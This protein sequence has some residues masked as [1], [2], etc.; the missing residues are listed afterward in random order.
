MLLK[1]GYN[2]QNSN[3]RYSV[4]SGV[5]LLLVLLAACVPKVKPP[6]TAPQALVKIRPHQFPD[7]SDDMSY[8]S[9]ETA[10]NQSLDYLNRLD[11]S[12]PFRFGPDTFT[13]SHL[14][15]SINAFH[16]LIKQAPSV[17]ELRKAIETSYWVYRSVGSD[18]QGKVMFTGYYEPAL[19]GSMR[20]SP[21]YP[22]PI[23]RKPDDWVRI[24][25]GLFNPKYAGERIVGRYVNESVVPC[26]SREEIDSKGLLLQKGSELLWVSDRVDLFFLHIQGSGRVLLEDGTVLHVNYDC[27]N[28]RPYRSIG[29]LLIDEGTIPKEEISMQRIRA[30]MN[31]HPEDIE[32]VFNHNQSYVFFRLVDQ[33]PMGALEV[34]LTPGRSVATDLRLFPRA[35][36]AF[37][38][39]EKP[40]VV[41]DGTIQSW[42][43]FGRFVL[44]QD[45]GGAIRGPGRLDLFWG[46]GQYAEM[47]AGH[48]KH[49]GTLYLLV[50]KQFGE[51][52]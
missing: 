30:Y 38:Q 5:L 28:G 25:L 12:T 51:R 36:L 24:D 22:Y 37:I 35:A 17:D 50:L 4:L 2:V 42:E 13:A 27:N 15:K 44:N 20:P 43:T 21:D 33:G 39:S 32:R 45:T 10:I 1:G 6:V 8:D 11:P 49:D 34:P 31:N 26:F 41:E 9:L 14:A 46:G 29:R 18:G 19:Q 7:F 47:A 23:Y 16:E 48:M 52:H 40:S 3:T